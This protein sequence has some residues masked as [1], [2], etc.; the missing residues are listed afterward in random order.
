MEVNDN[1][2]AVLCESSYPPLFDSWLRKPFATTGEHW[3]VSIPW[4]LTIYLSHKIFVTIEIY[5]ESFKNKLLMHTH[6][7]AS[8]F[9]NIMF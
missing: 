2:S 5:D 9:L 4:T 1:T 8:C 6:L 7:N 3:T